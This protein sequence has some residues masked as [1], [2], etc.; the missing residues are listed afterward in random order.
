MQRPQFTPEE[1]Y[2]I[3]LSKSPAVARDR[4][5]MWTYLA[6]GIL[7]AAFAAYYGNMPMMLAAFVVVCGFRIYEERYQ[8]RWEEPL[9]TL[10]Q[11]YEAAFD[12]N[13]VG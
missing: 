8:R 1:Q 10:I 3:N 2:I 5:Y 9:R 7:V 11:K 13:N 4:T 12:N 6:S